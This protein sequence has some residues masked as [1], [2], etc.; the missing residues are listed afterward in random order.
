MLWKKEHLRANFG[1]TIKETGLF[2]SQFAD[3][4]IGLDDNSKFIRSSERSY[5]KLTKLNAKMSF[6]FCFREK[7]GLMTT[8]YWV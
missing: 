5:K 7:G 1:C 3:G 2:K 4:I 6:G 8:D